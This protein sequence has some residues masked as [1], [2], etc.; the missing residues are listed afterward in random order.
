M[1]SNE[2]LKNLAF[3]VFL[4]VCKNIHLDKVEAVRKCYK[5]Q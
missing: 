3:G 5:T 4:H 1:F 2:A